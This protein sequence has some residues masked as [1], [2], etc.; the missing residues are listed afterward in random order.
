MRGAPGDT[1]GPLLPALL[2]PAC[3]RYG[4]VTVPSAVIGS[5]LDA[6]AAAA[7]LRVVRGGVSHPPVHVQR[8]GGD[9]RDLP[10][11]HPPA[12]RNTAMTHPPSCDRGVS[13]LESAGCI[14]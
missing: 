2:Q 12:A 13:V 9:R 8:C 1:P 14:C 11:L 7:G 3:I 10:H 5:V 6:D 4:K